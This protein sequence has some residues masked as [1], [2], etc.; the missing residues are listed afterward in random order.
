LIAQVKRL[1]MRW[2]GRHPRAQPLSRYLE[3]DL[4]ESERLALEG[5]LGE[6]PDCRALL[7]SLNDTVDALGS[8]RA[9]ARVGLADSVIAAVRAHD[10]SPGTESARASLPQRSPAL[11]L[12]PDWGAKPTDVA[13]GTRK[14]RRKLGGGV[15][16]RLAYCLQWRKLRLTLTLSLL[17][18]LALSLI[19]QGNMIFGGRANVLAICL[20][21]SPNF[22]IPFVALNV[23]VLLAT[24]VAPRRRL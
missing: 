14:V 10:V 15:R 12:L 20:A 5:H 7:R 6:C 13:T 11:T 16:A 9:G 2:G 3:G 17:V 24:Q 19:N 22:V 1:S 8:L 23:G 4:S 21:C 18:G